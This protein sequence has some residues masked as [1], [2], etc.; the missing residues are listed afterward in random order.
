MRFHLID[1]LRG[2]AATWVVFFHAYEGKHIETLSETLPE[3]I[4]FILFKMGHAGVPIFFV[5]SGFV[6]A[7]S[8]TRDKVNFNYIGKFT[9]RR[10]IRLDP[11][12][13]GS[14]ILV[15]SMAWLS[16]EVKNEAMEWPTVEMIFAHIF[17]MQNIFELGNINIIYWTLC[18]EVQFYLTFALLVSFSQ[19]FDR[20]HKSSNRVVFFTAA[21]V[22][23]LWPTEILKTNLYSGLFFPH[24]H[25]FLLGVFAYWSWQEK[26]SKLFF[27]I[28]FSI[29]L[30]FS[31]SNS[32]EFSLYSALAAILIH[33]LSIRGHVS[34]ANWRWIQF[35]GAISYSL[36]L[37]HNPIT[38]ASYFVI[39]KF[40]GKSLLTESLALLITTIACVVSAFIFW[41]IFEKW[42]MKLS[43][44]IKL[45]RGKKPEPTLAEV[46]S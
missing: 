28:Y 41:L 8:I 2:I 44:K 12:Y 30:I 19:Y 11:P 7:H 21:M 24:W 10:S 13:W 3:I 43:K 17:Y 20:Y 9:L 26:I 31:A 22:S 35:L 34:S 40:F 46:R 16:S 1:A 37:T 33:E 18:L 36:Y 15:I 23:L 14:I 5:L 25:A 29:I 39:Y 42:S 27:Y 4:V 45:H 6:I 38:G 32:S